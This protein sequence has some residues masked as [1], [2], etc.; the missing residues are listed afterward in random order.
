MQNKSCFCEY[1]QSIIQFKDQFDILTQVQVLHT[2]TKLQWKRC[3]DIPIKATRI[4][5]VVI[6]EKVYTGGGVTDPKEEIYTVLLYDMVKDEWGRLPNHCVGLFALGGF[7]GNLV[8]VGGEP[9]TNKVYRYNEETQEWEEF[10]TQMPT[11]RLNQTIL[12]LQQIS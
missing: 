12:I 7:Q 11:A 4:Q 8:T 5:V 2:Q 10:L 1:R 9:R 6:G 3:A